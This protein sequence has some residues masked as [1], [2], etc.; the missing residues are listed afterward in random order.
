MFL[1]EPSY[2]EQPARSID[3]FQVEFALGTRWVVFR[4]PNLVRLEAHKFF[5]IEQPQAIADSTIGPAGQDTWFFQSTGA[6]V[7]ASQF[8]PTQQLPIPSSSSMIG[9]TSS[10]YTAE[11]GA[12]GAVDSHAQYEQWLGA[13]ATQQQHQTQQQQSAGMPQMTMHTS[14]GASSSVQAPRPDQ[15]AAAFDFLQTQ[16]P[17]TSAMAQYIGSSANPGNPTTVQSG[18]GG[19]E[20]IG[21]ATS[22]PTHADIFSP[23]YPDLQSVTGS[24]SSSPDQGALSYHTSTPDSTIHTYSNVSDPGY[25]QQRAQPQP[26][27]S[28]PQ[29]PQLQQLPQQ[30]IQAP[31]STHPRQRTSSR[32]N[33]RNTIPSQKASQFQQQ[34]PPQS[35]FPVQQS[36]AKAAL[37]MPS[38]SNPSL[39]HS[40]SLGPQGV[41]WKGDLRYS[42]G[43]PATQPFYQ[44]TATNLPA[45]A[46]TSQAGTGSQHRVTSAASTQGSE[47][48]SL[49]SRKVS[50]KRK[51]QK[52]NDVQEASNLSG[53]DSDEDDETGFGM[54][55]GISVGMG[56][57]GVLGKG[58]KREKSG[59]L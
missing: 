31:R 3:V 1:H 56:G 36:P 48:G 51:R 33:P 52:R 20:T 43:S 34:H 53:M 11:G 41:S 32:T 55:G 27:F 19:L 21:A 26:S 50:S 46:T 29:P 35:R 45:A 14:Y 30:P 16:F 38:Q 8:E 22:Y 59:R 4:F 37:V 57:L 28:S 17:P 9:P 44:V 13:Y 25:Q 15:A 49:S 47:S 7:E 5:L 58:G 24:S 40:S 12:I 2:F 18:I 54:S 39:S 10:F 6:S 42:Q 23:F